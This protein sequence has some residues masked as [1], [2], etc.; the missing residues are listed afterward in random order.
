M[1]LLFLFFYNNLYF[2]VCVKIILIENILK[3]YNLTLNSYKNYSFYYNI[4]IFTKI[5]TFEILIE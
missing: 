4:L 2:I 1:F 5:F 3:I